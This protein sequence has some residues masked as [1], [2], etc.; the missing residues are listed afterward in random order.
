MGGCRRTL[1]YSRVSV[2]TSQ[3][4]D[5]RHAQ[6]DDSL[7]TRRTLNRTTRRQLSVRTP[8]YLI[9]NLNNPTTQPFPAFGGCSQRSPPSLQVVVLRSRV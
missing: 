6:L 5:A 2:A 1:I 4:G 7:A 8:A 9:S 3:D